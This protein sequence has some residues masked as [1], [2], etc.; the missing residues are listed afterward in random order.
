M[1]HAMIVNLCDGKLHVAAN[2]EHVQNIFHLGIGTESGF[3]ENRDQLSSVCV[4]ML[5]V[6][7][8]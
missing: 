3:M 6:N 8:G 4:R 1:T 2:G 7:S 5:R